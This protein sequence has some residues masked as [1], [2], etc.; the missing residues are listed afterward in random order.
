MKPVLLCVIAVINVIGAILVVCDKSR[1]KRKKRRIREATLWWISLL[2]GATL[3]F[4]FM[5]L[6]RHKTNHLSYMLL[7]P[8]ITAVQLCLLIL[9]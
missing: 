5:L 4:V 2:G 3:V 8:L 6:V 9:I 1:S 7:L